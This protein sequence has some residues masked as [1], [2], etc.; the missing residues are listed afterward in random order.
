MRS[1]CLNRRLKATWRTTRTAQGPSYR[2]G[3]IERLST[4]RPR[5]ADEAAEP[6]LDCARGPSSSKTLANVST[7]ARLI[8]NVIA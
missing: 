1:W 5:G 4:D 3:R 2:G 7:P 6:E 8:T